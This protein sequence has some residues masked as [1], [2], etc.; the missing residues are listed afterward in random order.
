MEDQQ[1][2]IWLHSCPSLLAGEPGRQRGE[3]KPHC[4]TADWDGSGKLHDI[5]IEMFLEDPNTPLLLLYIDQSTGELCTA[6]GIPPVQ[7]EQASYF[8]R[9]KNVAVTESNFHT[10]LQTGMVHG[11]YVDT[12]PH[13]MQGLYAPNF[14]ENKTWPDSNTTCYILYIQAALHITIQVNIN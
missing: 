13:V 11:N 1:L 8:V 14:F 4:I 12:L 6:N 10:A 9:S 3:K 2:S 5:D 7:F